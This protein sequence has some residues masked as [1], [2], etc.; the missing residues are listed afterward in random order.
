MVIAGLLV[1][2]GMPDRGRMGGGRRS[3]ALEAV[4]E[5]EA[6]SRSWRAE[7]RSP[8]ALLGGGRRGPND[9]GTGSVLLGTGS[10]G[11]DSAERGPLRRKMTLGRVRRDG[12]GSTRMMAKSRAG[13][14]AGPHARARILSSWAPRRAA[15]R[16]GTP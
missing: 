3:D 11:T 7:E 15:R 16:P 4:P 1:T 9:S 12:T 6:L 13:V 10:V 14:A 5:A 2:A 8:L